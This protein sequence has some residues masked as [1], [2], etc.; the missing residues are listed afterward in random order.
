MTR[1]T[2]RMNDSQM[3]GKRCTVNGTLSVVLMHRNRRFASL[4]RQ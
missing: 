1:T 3:R 4:S 2:L